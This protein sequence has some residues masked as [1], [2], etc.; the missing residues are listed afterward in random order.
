M[1]NPCALDSCNLIHL[2][3]GANT[4]QY[5]SRIPSVFLNHNK[6]IRVRITNYNNGLTEHG[7][8]GNIF[9][10][11]MNLTQWYTLQL[12]QRQ[13]GPEASVFEFSVDGSRIQESQATLNHQSKN[14]KL[15]LS[16]PWY[17]SA[18]DVVEVKNIL[19]W[20]GAG[21]LNSNLL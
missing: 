20:N 9:E 2:T 4:G 3:R 12:E 1:R 21:E 15:Y 16:D 5:G 8:Y 18:L 14:V 13:T 10:H 7:G 6:K 19:I 11:K 17:A